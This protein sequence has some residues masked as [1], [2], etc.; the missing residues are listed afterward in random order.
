MLQL[1]HSVQN[2]TTIGECNGQQAEDRPLIAHV[3][4]GDL[5]P[6]A[7]PGKPV[8]VLDARDATSWFSLLFCS[9]NSC[10]D[11]LD[12]LRS[13]SSS[14][15]RLSLLVPTVSHPTRSFIRSFKFR[16]N[17]SSCRTFGNRLGI[18]GT[19]HGHLIRLVMTLPHGR[20][21]FL[22]S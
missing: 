9:C 2:E 18:P 21:R 7:V 1:G 6:F 17:N 19:N 12:T 22:V 3:H 14:R 15:S 20:K 11:N 8:I 16:N 4:N 10:C 5:Q 13:D